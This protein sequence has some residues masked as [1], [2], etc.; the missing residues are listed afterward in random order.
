MINIVNHGNEVVTLIKFWVVYIVSLLK[1]IFCFG[2]VKFSLDK[3]IMT[4]YLS[5]GKYKILTN[6][7]KFPHP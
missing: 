1:L 7:S 2:Q 3:Y 6:L 5:L 4:I